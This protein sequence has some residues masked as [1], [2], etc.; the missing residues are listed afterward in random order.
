MRKLYGIFFAF[1]FVMLCIPDSSSC[2]N[3]S[4]FFLDFVRHPEQQRN[5]VLFPFQSESG[6]VKSAKSYQPLRLA[7]P[8]NIPIVCTDSL[9]LVSSQK[10]VN[11]SVVNML[12]IKSTQYSFEKKNEKWKLASSGKDADY[13]GERDFVEFLMQYSRDV[14]FQKKRTIFPFPYRIYKENKSNELSSKLMMPREWEPFDFVALF[15]SLCVFSYDKSASVN[16]RRLF[17]M[18][19]GSPYLFFNFIS[20]NKKWYLIEMEEYR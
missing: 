12:D 17:V 13:G 8:V 5:S 18:K 6:V 19:N 1:L 11:V 2:Q 4:T 9:N 7:T 10:V 20:I 16:N 15:P 14:D 3:F